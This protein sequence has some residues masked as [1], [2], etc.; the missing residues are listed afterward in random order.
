[1]CTDCEVSLMRVITGV[2]RG[3]RLITVAGNDIVR[4]TGEKV[5]EALFSSIQFDIE[6]RRVLDL[7]AGSGQLGIE[8]LSRGAES[9][10]F[11]DNN[12]A[13]LKAVKQ[14]LESTGLVD[15]AIVQKSDY[16]TF[17][18]RCAQKFDIAFLDPPYQA[19]ILE[20]AVSKVI[21]LMSDYGKIF[22]EHPSELKMP[23]IIASFAVCKVY[24]YGKTL[25][26]V[27]KKDVAENE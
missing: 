3:K 1:M 24:K 16:A 9:C 6:G 17:A 2:A 14:N 11:V 10:I 7:F 27:Y 8:A 21:P 19:G 5:K 18:M 4:P 20:D 12:D 13:S 25:I 26:T 23:E 22:C 15:K